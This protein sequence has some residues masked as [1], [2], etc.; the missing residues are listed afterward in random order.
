MQGPS[1][2]DQWEMC[3]RYPKDQDGAKLLAARRNHEESNNVRL[4]INEWAAYE[5]EEQ[6]SRKRMRARGYSESTVQINL[7]LQW[8]ND[9]GNRENALKKNILKWKEYIV[10][11][12]KARKSVSSAQ[13]HCVVLCDL[14]FSAHSN[15]R[16]SRRSAR[17]RDERVEREGVQ[18]STTHQPFT[19]SATRTC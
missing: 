14:N 17:H 8:L 3:N 10:E 12:T 5:D 19:I 16:R 13:A 9:K 18:P 11:G 1:E 4:G 15:L 2:I 6:V 7:L